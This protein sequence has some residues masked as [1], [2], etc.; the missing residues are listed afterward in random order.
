VN[1]KKTKITCQ[2]QLTNALNEEIGL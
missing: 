2:G 1:L